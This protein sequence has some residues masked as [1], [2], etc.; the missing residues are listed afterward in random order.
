MAN[1]DPNARI[2]AAPDSG[3]PVEPSWRPLL[4]VAGCLAA[5]IGLGEFFLD[6][7]LEV[8]E[9]IGEGIFFVVEGSE[10][11]LEDKIEEWFDLD[12]FHAEIVTAWGMTPV[13]LLLGFLVL[14]WLW[15]KAHSQ[16]L[17]RV[18]AYL[19]RQVRAVLLAWG[20]LPWPYKA[21][22]AMAAFGALAVLI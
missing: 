6:V 13:K 15:R 5:I 22:I 12:P 3:I 18:V 20:E 16:L 21:M 14:R 8:L 17:P 2:P 10:E 1:S 9:L 7:V 4:W 11:H 19:K